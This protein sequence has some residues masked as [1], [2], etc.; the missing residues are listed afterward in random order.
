MTFGTFKGSCFSVK[1]T[2]N[3]N[4]SNYH[5]KPYSYKKNSNPVLHLQHSRQY[6]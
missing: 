3:C 4:P 1:D 6:K 5:N 2:G